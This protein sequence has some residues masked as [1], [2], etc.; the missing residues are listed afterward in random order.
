MG[1]MAS[2][3]QPVNSL[4]DLRPPLAESNQ[5]NPER[6]EG[7]GG[8][9]GHI[10]VRLGNCL[11]DAAA[12]L[13]VRAGIANNE[14]IIGRMYRYIWP[15]AEKMGGARGSVQAA[16]ETQE[17]LERYYGPSYEDRLY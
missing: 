5:L 14:A 16:Q 11:R 8:G 15:D 10:K 13:E 17:E 6:Q 9:E 1:E 2:R 3:R 12:V 4:S 7:Q